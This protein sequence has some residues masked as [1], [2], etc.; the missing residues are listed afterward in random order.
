MIIDHPVRHRVGGGNQTDDIGALVRLSAV[1]AAAFM[2]VIL[3]L[4]P[5]VL[6]VDR[7][8][9][10]EGVR[11]IAAPLRSTDH[12]RWRSLARRPDM[13]FIGIT[14]PRLLA[15]TPWTDDPQPRRRLSATASTPRHRSPACG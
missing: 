2:P 7:F 8:A 3:S 4:D 9:D 14:F 1:A 6:E 5:N 10:L 12:M 15:R 11:D 13:R